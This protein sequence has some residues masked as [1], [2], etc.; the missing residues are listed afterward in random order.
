MGINFCECKQC[1]PQM[2]SNMT[3]TYQNLARE[4]QS[5][6]PTTQLISNNQPLYQNNSNSRPLNTFNNK[7][8]N[9][10]NEITNIENKMLD[11]SYP[12]G[13]NNIDVSN[14]NNYNYNNNNTLSYRLTNN[15]PLKVSQSI[16]TKD[17]EISVKNRKEEEKSQKHSKTVLIPKIKIEFPKNQENLININKDG[18]AIRRI[19]EN[20]YYIGI[21]VKGKIQGIGKYVTETNKYLGEFI[22]DIA[23]GFGLFNNSN[24]CSIFEG[25]WK[26]NKQEGF[27]IEKFFDGSTHFGEYR[28]GYKNG[29][30]V[31]I[32]H[33]GSRYEGE[34]KNNLFDGYGLYYY[35]DNKI[36]LGEWKN[37]K[38]HGCGELIYNDKIF[39]GWFKR[40]Q[41]EG[42]GLTYWINEDKLFFGFWKKGKK[43][44]FG[45][46]FHGEKIRFGL[47][48]NDS[49][50]LWF[51]DDNQ[52][53]EYLERNGLGEFSG[54]FEYEKNDI[55]EKFDLN[56][57]GD[58][59]NPVNISRKIIL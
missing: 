2:E 32:S 51:D 30:G 50:S 56:G 23:N 14:Y 9:L 54:L 36:Y 40:D 28:N 41:K 33:D 39:V 55:I 7:S 31:F 17:I 16:L 37:N 1:G 10:N 48:K 5:D 29:K 21:F 34:F 25:T 52:A 44:G 19:S 13:N 46:Y 6:F 38:K 4:N 26:N 53:Y 15:T 8:A 18:F 45:K 57:Y 42:I 27:G 11:V 43:E 22:N 59:T 24:T 12:H 20:E 3:K 35:K 49:K 58:I 47:W